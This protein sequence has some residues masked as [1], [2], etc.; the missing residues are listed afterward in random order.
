MSSIRH[1][2]PK[3][4]MMH[5]SLLLVLPLQVPNAA[6]VI[7]VV[8]AAQE[9]YCRSSFLLLSLQ[10]RPAAIVIAIEGSCRV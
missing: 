2:P 4:N 8:V 3:A 9:C 7:T 5:P 10:Q 1:T 6:V